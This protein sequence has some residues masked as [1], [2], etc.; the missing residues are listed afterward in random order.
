MWIDAGRNWR[1][2]DGGEGDDL[3]EFEDEIDWNCG[4]DEAMKDKDYISSVKKAISES[5]IEA[6]NPKVN[7]CSRGKPSCDGC[8]FLMVGGTCIGVV[9]PTCPPQFD[10]CEFLR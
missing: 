9:Y 6:G 7:V 4:L 8:E 1:I 10:K 2:R 5:L 3:L